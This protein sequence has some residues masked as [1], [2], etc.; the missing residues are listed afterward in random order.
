MLSLKVLEVTRQRLLGLSKIEIVA[1]QPELAEDDNEVLMN[2]GDQGRAYYFDF[3]ID[4]E[5][6]GSRGIEGYISEDYFKMTEYTCKEEKF[7]NMNIH[8]LP[9]NM[10]ED[11]FF[12]YSLVED[13]GDLTVEKLNAI[14]EIRDIIRENK[15]DWGVK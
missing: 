2:Y 15:I 1:A 10:G 3:N 14:L 6:G 9:S 4:L 8:K 13:V 11:E 7:F 5:G 12:Q